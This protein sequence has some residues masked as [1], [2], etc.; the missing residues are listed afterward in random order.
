MYAN[1]FYVGQKFNLGEKSV[2]LDDIKEFAQKYDPFPFHTNEELASETIFKGIISSGWQTAL[3]WL[4]M[5]HDSF[6]NYDTV[7]GSPGHDSLIWK[8][9]VRPGD[10]LSGEIEIL[11]VKLSKSRPEIGFVKY[12]AVLI[13]QNDDEVFFTESSLI[14]KTK[15]NK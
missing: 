8:N 6:L 14:I 1:E 15:Y 9:P 11:G 10:T 4:G 13:N 3:V 7:L 5:M 2:S 12:R